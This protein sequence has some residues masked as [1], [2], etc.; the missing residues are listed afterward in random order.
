[1]DEFNRTEIFYSIVDNDYEKF[2]AEIESVKDINKVDING[3]TLLHFCGEYSRSKFATA[4]IDKGIDL[5]IKDKFGNNALWKACFNS[6]GNYEL[7]EILVENQANS[8]SKNNSN[9]SPLELAITMGDE[10]LIGLLS[11]PEFKY[12]ADWEQLANLFNYEIDKDNQDWTY[13]ISEPERI[14][15]YLD[16]Y[17][18]IQN[19][20]G[21]FSLMEMIIQSVNGQSDNN[22]D[23]Y[24]YKL[25]PLLDIDFELNKPTIYYWCVW[26]NSDLED[27]FRISEKMRAYWINKVK[28]NVL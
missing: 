25:L 5:E 21:K 12:F 1:M 2:L 11:E 24:W 18:K 28:N 9:K 19:K 8:K 23:H 26:M 22:F 27:C 17:E 10:R 6:R 3:M 13:T 4:L 20:E 14:D 16:A 15:E 7:V